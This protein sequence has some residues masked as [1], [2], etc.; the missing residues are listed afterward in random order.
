MVDFVGI[1]VE[2]K[3]YHNVVFFHSKPNFEAINCLVAPP[4]HLQAWNLP[5]I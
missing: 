5:S 3:V 1:Y 2:I 4:V